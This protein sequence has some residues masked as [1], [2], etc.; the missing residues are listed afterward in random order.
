M[1]GLRELLEAKRQEIR[2]QME[3][4]TAKAAELR[5][6]LAAQDA[7]LRMLTKELS[8]L[9]RAL[10]VI[11]K[12]QKLEATITIK[13]AILETLRGAPKG[14]TAADILVAINDRHFEGTIMR[15]SM[16]PQLYRLKDR[17]KKIKQIG[18]KYFLA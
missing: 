13:E 14:M 6:Q 5:T 12:K 17:D 8:D 15:T 18:D 4:I 10:Q 9:D 11:G 7:K 16:S 2:R 3:P 1:S